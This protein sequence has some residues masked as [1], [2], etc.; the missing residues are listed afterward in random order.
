[1]SHEGVLVGWFAHLNAVVQQKSS[2]GSLAKYVP[3]PGAWHSQT[4]FPI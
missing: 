1:M 3:C 2:L 4:D